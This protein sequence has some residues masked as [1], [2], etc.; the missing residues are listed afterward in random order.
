MFSGFLVKV[1]KQVSSSLVPI[2][3]IHKLRLQEEVVK[4]SIWWPNNS[5]VLNKHVV[6]ILDTFKNSWK[7]SIGYFV[8]FL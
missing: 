5:V 4:Y 7:V 6:W 3:G 2:R 8:H 1:Y